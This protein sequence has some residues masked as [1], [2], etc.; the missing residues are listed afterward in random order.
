MD[1]VYTVGKHRTCN[2]LEFQILFKWINVKQQI[3]QGHYSIFG[4]TAKLSRARFTDLKRTC[5][6][7]INLS[8]LLSTNIKM[9]GLQMLHT[10]FLNFSV[11]D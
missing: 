1:Y 8:Y 5:V 9:E 4:V 3:K 10:F 6:H 2:R 11:Q 7:I